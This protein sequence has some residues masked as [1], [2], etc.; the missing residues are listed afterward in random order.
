LN[1]GRGGIINPKRPVAADANGLILL[2]LSEHSGHGRTCYWFAPVTND[3]KQTILKSFRRR[4]LAGGGYVHSS[5]QASVALLMIEATT[6]GFD[7]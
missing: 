7:T 4:L 6:S 2:P 1:H 3:P 5:H